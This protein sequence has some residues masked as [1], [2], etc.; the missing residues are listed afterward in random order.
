ML[1][2]TALCRPSAVAAILT[3]LLQVLEE[4][5]VFY[6]EQDRS[7]SGRSHNK[8]GT[9]V[10]QPS[11]GGQPVPDQQQ[12]RQGQQQEQQP[13]QQPAATA[14]LPDLPAS[15]SVADEAVLAGVG[16]TSDESMGKA[17]DGGQT[18]TVLQTQLEQG[19]AADPGQAAG[20]SDGRSSSHSVGTKRCAACGKDQP[21]DG[22]KLR[23]CTGCRA[24]RY[25]NSECQRNHWA[26]HRAACKRGSARSS[27]T[28]YM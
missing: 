20:P 21:A 6:G 10:E 12:R 14:H 18:R 28:I 17:Q 5:R 16:S 3:D 23:V 4:A 26:K 11:R 2:G 8:C 24:V 1:Y 9:A 27:E 7:E 13:Q 15:G 22:G 19:R 25:C